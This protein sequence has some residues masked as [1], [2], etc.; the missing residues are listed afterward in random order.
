[1]LLVRKIFANNQPGCTVYISSCLESQLVVVSTVCSEK[2]NE[3]Q[4]SFLS[5]KVMYFTVE[6]IFTHLSNNTI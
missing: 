2:K 5:C 6:V 4:I 3:R 1:M